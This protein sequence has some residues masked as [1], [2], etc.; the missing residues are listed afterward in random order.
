[1]A[2]SGI[3]NMD[4]IIKIARDGGY[5]E[6]AYCSTCGNECGYAYVID[7]RFWQAL[8]RACGWTEIYKNCGR[9]SIE[10][11]ICDFDV[12]IP[13]W[14]FHALRFHEINLTRGWKEAVDPLQDLIK[15][16]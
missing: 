3:T 10:R 2:S 11:C 7:S 8:G 13:E 5:S 12:N 14:K 6:Q 9:K 16:K 15:T 1:M 4:E